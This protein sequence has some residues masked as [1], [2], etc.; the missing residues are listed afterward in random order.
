MAE[1][2]GFSAAAMSFIEKLGQAVTTAGNQNG[3]RVQQF[4][5]RGFNCDVTVGAIQLKLTTGMTP[6][7]DGGATMRMRSSLTDR[8]FTIKPKGD[9]ELALVDENGKATDLEAFIDAVAEGCDAPIK[10]EI[11]I[12]PP[13]ARFYEQLGATVVSAGNDNGWL[14]T[15]FGSKGFN[16]DVAVGSTILKLTTDIKPAGDGS[17]STVKLKCRDFER[18]L[19]T[20]AGSDGNLELVDGKNQVVEGKALI[21]LI[22]EGCGLSLKEDGEIPAVL[23]RTYEKIATTVVKAGQDNGWKVTRF[24]ARGFNCDVVIGPNIVKLTTDAKS[25]PDGGGASIWFKR[26][27]N[28]WTFVTKVMKDG[29][30][31]LVDDKG[32]GVDLHKFIELL[33]IALDA[34]LKAVADMPL[35]L[36]RF[37]EKVA[38]TIVNAG[39]DNGWKVTLF[40]SRGVNSDVA[41]GPNIGKVTTQGTPNPDGSGVTIRIVG[42][43]GER[44]LAVR[45]RKDGELEM[46]DK[47][48]AVSTEKFLDLLAESCGAAIIREEDVPAP[49]NRLIEKIASTVGTCG[50]DNGWNVIRFGARGYNADLTVGKN[51]MKLTTEGKPA[52]DGAGAIFRLKRPGLEKKFTSRAQPGGELELADDAGAVAF[53]R[54][55]EILKEAAKY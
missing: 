28:T 25:G 47:D 14:V 38:N 17:G 8:T 45:L 26:A 16:T 31:E 48:Q 44:N 33:A 53:E 34:P 54:L 24:G 35:P 13:L 32:A 51:V 7:P 18:V 50:V 52:A 30:L 22:A 39:N 49:L 1:I 15:P 27:G 5:R 4:G 19:T 9:G 23:Q 21:D 6:T 55:V 43:G 40:G 12:P 46:A 3:W 2:P 10:R 20:R 36:V 11:S 41:I 37:C 29:E 42:A